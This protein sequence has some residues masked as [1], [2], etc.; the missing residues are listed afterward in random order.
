MQLQVGYTHLYMQG[1]ICGLY[2]HGQSS[3][4]TCTYYR[5]KRNLPPVLFYKRPRQ[6][7]QIQP[8]EPQDTVVTYSNLCYKGHMVQQ[9]T[10]YSSTRVPML[11]KCNMPLFFLNTLF[12]LAKHR[13]N[14]NRSSL[15]HQYMED[16]I[17][18]TG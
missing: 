6:V 18:D 7:Q 9:V 17:Y 16:P 3:I 10:W 11:K 5:W 1:R 14:N 12:K 13:Y 8:I 4:A 2:L 15:D